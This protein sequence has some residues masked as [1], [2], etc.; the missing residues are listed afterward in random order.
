MGRIARFGESV[1]RHRPAFPRFGEADIEPRAA[2]AAAARSDPGLGGVAE[3]ETGGAARDRRQR[4]ARRRLAH[5]GARADDDIGSRFHLAF[6]RL[7]GVDA[8]HAPRG[9]EHL[10]PRV[11]KRYAARSEP[12]RDLRRERRGPGARRCAEQAG[13]FAGVIQ[14]PGRRPAPCERI[15]ASRV[16]GGQFG[17]DRMHNMLRVGDLGL[18]DPAQLPRGDRPGDRRS[19]QQD[20]VVRLLHQRRDPRRIA[21]GVVVD[22][23]AALALEHPQWFRIERARGG[24]QA[25]DL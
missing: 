19:G 13:R 15:G 22:D 12:A 24:E 23:I 5:R 3:R 10:I 2:H 21:I 1:D 8:H 11:W 17:G 9:D 7:R 4:I 25:Q 14:K 20:N 6:A 16:V 18:V